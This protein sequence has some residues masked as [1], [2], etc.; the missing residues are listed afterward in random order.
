[1]LRAFILVFALFAG[2]LAAWFSF[3]SSGAV[4][5]V[6]VA[7]PSPAPLPTV[8][9]LV[10][11]SDLVSGAKLSV[12]SLRWQDWPEASLSPGFITRAARPD[13]VAELSGMMTRTSFL[14]GEPVHDGRLMGAGSGYLSVMLTAGMRAVAVRI[15]AENTAGGFILPNDHVDVLHTVSQM[16]PAGTMQVQSRVLLRN[17][18]VLAID[19]M[20][21]DGQIDSVVG[22][23]ATLELDAAQVAAITAAETSGAISLALRA[24]VD[25]AESSVID[26]AAPRTIQ[27]YR[28]G[29]RETVHIATPTTPSNP[30]ETVGY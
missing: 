7:A 25:N 12:D 29:A 10:S 30:P 1:M 13:A 14:G 23:T 24:L 18:R 8:E 15:S 27:I 6:L 3:S 5:N 26:I 9:V 20:V 11:A 16:D 2:G 4:P 22:K 21:A 17:V 19:Q 28:A